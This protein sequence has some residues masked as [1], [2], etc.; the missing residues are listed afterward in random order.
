MNGLSIDSGALR[1]A[2]IVPE[3]VV[4][5]PAEDEG[6]ATAWHGLT[7]TKADGRSAVVLISIS[8]TAFHPNKPAGDELVN[9]LRARH[10]GGSARVEQFTTPGGHPGV[11]VRRVATQRVNG[12][13]VTT[14]QTQ[15]LVAYPGVEALGVVSG[16]ALDPTDLDRA[17]GLVTE[18]AAGMT[19][20]CAPAAALRSGRI[21]IP[22]IPVC[23]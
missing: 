5:M 6:E 15:A 13:D 23:R 14:G 3:D 10:P 2:V 7:C 8:M 9:R 18:I 20:T 17:A 21:G 22:K 4:G 19:V 11:C 1:A 12:R 16:V